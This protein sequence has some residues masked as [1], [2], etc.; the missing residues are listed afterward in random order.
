MRL[1]A[2]LLPARAALGGRFS[3]RDLRAALI[4]GAARLAAG[5]SGDPAAIPSEAR[6]ICNSC[7]SPFIPNEHGGCAHCDYGYARTIPAVELHAQ[8][9]PWDVRESHQVSSPGLYRNG[10]RFRSDSEIS[11]SHTSHAPVMLP[12]GEYR[13]YVLQI[14]DAD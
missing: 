6:I 4:C 14:A 7:G 13:L 1:S 5:K 12:P 11:V 9:E 3:L 2:C 10:S 8:P